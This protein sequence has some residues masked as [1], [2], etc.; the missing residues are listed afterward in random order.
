VRVTYQSLQQIPGGSTFAAH[1]L[2]DLAMY[3]GRLGEAASTLELAIAAE[4]S[5]SLR[6]RLTLVLAEVRFAQGRAADALRLIDEIRPVVANDPV[7]GFEVGRLLLVSG[8][9]AEAAAIGA[10][11]SQG[12]DRETQ[13]LGGVLEADV[14][15]SAGN[16][17]AAL[18]LLDEARTRADSWLVRYVRARAFIAA[19]R[20]ADADSELELCQRRRGEAS[21]VFMDDI[22]TWRLMAA[23]KYYQAVAREG[24]GSPVAAESFKAFLA[25][26]DGGD[27]V[28][29]LVAEARKRLSA[30][31]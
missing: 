11:L 24:L 26:K 3:R 21:A 22:P 10:G 1:G 15:L 2:A 14:A 5:K 19:G 7:L 16:P 6:A 17:K 12:V 18:A 13:A 29:G 30:A 9:R 8:R 25:L 27:E 20:F 31:P 23:L 4:T 28:S